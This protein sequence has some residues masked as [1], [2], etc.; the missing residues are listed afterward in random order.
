[1]ACIFF[2]IHIHIHNH[3]HVYEF[4]DNICTHFEKTDL[5]AVLKIGKLKILPKGKSSYHLNQT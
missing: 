1:M 4:V 3:I 5:T 2:I